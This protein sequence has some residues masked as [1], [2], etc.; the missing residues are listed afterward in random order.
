MVAAKK[1]SQTASSSALVGVNVPQIAQSNAFFRIIPMSDTGTDAGT[2]TTYYTVPAQRK[3]VV[4]GIYKLQDN[5]LS[6]FTGNGVRIRNSGG[7]EVF[8]LQPKDDDALA[9]S[10]I[11]QNLI[12]NNKFELGPSFTV[13]MRYETTDGL[14]RLSYT[15]V[16]I[17]TDFSVPVVE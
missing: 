12:S 4:L 16:G 17:E 2:E 6:T 5:F 10:D 7:V 13:G 1:R 11:G 15:V 9:T 14:G 3:F 8:R